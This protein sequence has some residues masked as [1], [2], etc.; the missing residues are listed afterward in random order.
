M[1]SRRTS[2]R[3]AWPLFGRRSF[4]TVASMRTQSTVTSIPSNDPITQLA[5]AGLRD[6]PADE[7]KSVDRLAGAASR[8]LN[9]IVRRCGRSLPAFFFFAFVV[10]C[11]VQLFAAPASIRMQQLVQR[12]CAVV[13]VASDLGL[14]TSSCPSRIEA[15]D[16]MLGGAVRGL[17]TLA[18]SDANHCGCTPPEPITPRP[19][20]GAAMAL[21][22]VPPSVHRPRAAV[23]V[24]CRQVRA[25]VR[26][27]L[28]RRFQPLPAGR[29]R[30]APRRRL[31][32]LC[33]PPAPRAGRTRPRSHLG[34][35]ARRHDLLARGVAERAGGRGGALDAVRA[36]RHPRRPREPSERARRAVAVVGHRRG[37]RAA[38]RESTCTS[39]APASVLGA[40]PHGRGARARADC[41]SG[42]PRRVRRAVDDERGRLHER[43]GARGRAHELL[44]HACASSR[45]ATLLPRGLSHSWSPW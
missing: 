14:E 8:A 7:Q 27:P 13:C 25:A 28:R 16:A 10:V 32:G 41:G 4:A 17:V 19:E 15:G 23:R 6:T 43:R 24:S 18:Y 9:E 22:C 39:P 40:A 37:P 44:V 38:R 33:H 36:H 34:E 26:R 30:Q 31:Q 42:A 1:A 2:S 21:P 12:D 20:P 29:R 35:R 11:V 45:R 5:T 3:S